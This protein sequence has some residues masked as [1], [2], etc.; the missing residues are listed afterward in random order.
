MFCNIKLTNMFFLFIYKYTDKEDK[1]L[2]DQISCLS[3][4]TQN[5]QLQFSPLSFVDW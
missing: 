5:C 4:V 2:T 3:S 1:D